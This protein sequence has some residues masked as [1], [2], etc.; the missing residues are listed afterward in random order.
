MGGATKKKPGTDK[1]LV[2]TQ[3]HEVLG[4]LGMGAYGQV[5]KCFD[6]QHNEL[7]ALKLLP[8]IVG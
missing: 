4:V 6:H 3:A 7:V 2:G 1:V 8:T 5:L